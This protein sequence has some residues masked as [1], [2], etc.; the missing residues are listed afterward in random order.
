MDE[1][2]GLILGYEGTPKT[3]KPLRARVCGCVSVCVCAGV[4]V[5]V[6]GWT[7]PGT[8]FVLGGL[9]GTSTP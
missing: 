9:T 3:E 7:T 8:S 5:C 6:Y 2:E 1:P 4:G